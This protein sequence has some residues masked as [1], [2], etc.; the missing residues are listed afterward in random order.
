MIGNRVKAIWAKESHILSD[1]ANSLVEVRSVASDLVG[2]IYTTGQIR[3]E[4]K[5]GQFVLN[6]P[7]PYLFFSKQNRE[8]KFI[9][10]KTGILDGNASGDSLTL[11]NKGYLYLSGSFTGQLQFEGAK[12][13]SSQFS[14]LFVV[15]ID[16]A[17]GKAIW[18]QQAISDA[19]SLLE[20][21]SMTNDDHNIYLTGRFFGKLKFGTQI[22][23]SKDGSSAYATALN[24]KKGS[25]VWASQ[26]NP[27]GLSTSFGNSIALNNES[28]N[29][30]DIL[31]IC[32]QF[33]KQVSFG[34]I[35]LSTIGIL[36]SFVA[37]LNRK[38]GDWL[39]AVKTT[40]LTTA[41]I[42]LAKGIAVDNKNVVYII[43]MFGGQVTFGN[44]VIST[45]P[46]VRRET[47]VAK[48]DRK[49]NWKKTVVVESI[50]TKENVETNNA[51][52]IAVFNCDCSNET[53]IYI[54]GYFIG[55]AIFGNLDPLISIPN[56]ASYLARLTQKLDF[57]T[58]FQTTNLDPK[59]ESLVGSFQVI[60]V[61]SY[62]TVSIVGNFTGAIRIG[63]LLINSLAPFQ[64]GFIF[65]RNMNV[66]KLI[67]SDC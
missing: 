39:N 38:T 10:V 66:S 25:F 60:T 49:L 61:V 63:Q 5:I 54:T 57:D 34:S 59:A 27:V 14:T 30:N 15:K 28:D 12:K 52:G 6:G 17:T 46:N 29:E 3:G 7:P 37:T 20:S 43:G 64:P 19:T 50:N 22:L 18:A 36:D 58:A 42:S 32:G 11:D 41:S 67:I 31:Y 48:L 56:R 24:K 33:D 51:G 13:L 62:N 53:Y 55:H 35:D 40:S 8:G 47:F 65:G 1:P 44:E 45:P 26:V 4:A 2:N 23:E 16:S 21:T 9:Y